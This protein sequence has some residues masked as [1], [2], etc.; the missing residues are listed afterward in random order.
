MFITLA[1]QSQQ[2]S[3]TPVIPAADTYHSIGI[4]G[5]K[6]DV[7]TSTEFGIVLAGGSTDVDAAMQWM[8]SKSGGGDFIILRASGSTG[9]NDYLFNLG[10][11]NSVETLLLDSK[12][13]ANKEAVGKRIREAEAVFIA[14]GDQSNYV[15]FWS[16]T[17]VSKALNY[18]VNEKKVPIGGTSAGCAVLSQLVFDARQGSVTSVEAL[19]NPYAPTVSLSESFITIPFLQKT[20][21]DQHYSQRERLGRHVVFM[22]RM[23]KDFGLNEVFGIGVDERTAVCVDQLGNAQVFG[24]NKAY[25]LHAVQQAEVCEVNTPL[26]WTHVNQAIKAKIIQGSVSGTVAFNLQSWPADISE[27]WH[28]ENGVLVRGN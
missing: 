15:N 6:E 22:S 10:K 28:V 9:Y 24:S 27:Y 21:A 14:G 25:F 18:L 12:D 2:E 26:T 20:I 19:A 1:C 5:S 4:T 8:I 3:V 13:K 17:E 16:N 11:V 7:Q 23:L